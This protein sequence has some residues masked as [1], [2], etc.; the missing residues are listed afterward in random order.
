[1]ISI[2]LERIGLR[3]LSRKIRIP[4]FLDLRAF[5]VGG[6]NPVIYRGTCV[7]LRVS[8]CNTVST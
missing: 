1:M 6:D 3:P 7:L 5:R 4:D 2:G 8:F